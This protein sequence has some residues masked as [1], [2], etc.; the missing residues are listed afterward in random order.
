M[1]ALQNGTVVNVTLS[2]TVSLTDVND[3]APVFVK[4]KYLN[5]LTPYLTCPKIKKN[6]S[7]RDDN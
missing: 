1:K 4:R 7:K 2:V 6:K 5:S 3:N